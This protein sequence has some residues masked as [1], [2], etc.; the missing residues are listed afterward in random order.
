MHKEEIIPA[1]AIKEG[2]PGFFQEIMQDDQ[3][4]IPSYLH[5]NGSAV[6]SD[7]KPSEEIYRRFSFDEY[8]VA[9]D[10]VTAN[11]FSLRADSYNREKYSIQPEDVL[12]DV[13]NFSK[14]LLD[15]GILKLDV[16]QLQSL[17]NEEF[18]LNELIGEDRK[19]KIDV[20]IRHKPHPFMYSHSEMIFN[21]DDVEIGG[22][23]KFKPALLKTAYKGYLQE[24]AKILKKPGQVSDMS[25]LLE[26]TDKTR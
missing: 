7:F 12:L 3:L 16:S 22:K 6:D 19:I 21:L 9:K 1:L 8:E 17:R 5:T 23:K 4:L 15:Y 11:V 24:L 20:E 2:I 10:I 13:S 14:S 25:Y 18:N 26:Y